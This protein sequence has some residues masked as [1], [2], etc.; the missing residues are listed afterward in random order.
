LALIPLPRL[1]NLPRAPQSARTAPA[2]TRPRVAVDAT[3]FAANCCGSLGTVAALRSRVERWRRSLPWHRAADQALA[4]ALRATR[5]W[6]GRRQNWGWSAG[7]R[8]RG[9]QQP[10]TRGP[11]LPPLPVGEQTIIA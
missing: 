7:H 2:R 11:A 1:T 4:T 9:D 6:S 10:T 3:V 5:R 8:R